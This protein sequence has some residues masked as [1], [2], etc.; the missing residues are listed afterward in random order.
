MCYIQMV[1]C[2]VHDCLIAKRVQLCIKGLDGAICMNRHSINS[3]PC[4]NSISASKDL[5]VSETE[6]NFALQMDLVLMTKVSSIDCSIVEKH[7]L[8]FGSATD[9]ISMYE[10]RIEMQT[11]HTTNNRTKKSNP[12]LCSTMVLSTVKRPFTNRSLRRDKRKVQSRSGTS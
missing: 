6:N 11:D 2:H 1:N 10:N 3:M 4:I 7:V 9:I 5:L 12:V 8:E